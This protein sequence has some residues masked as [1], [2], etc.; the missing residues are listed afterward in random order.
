MKETCRQGQNTKQQIYALSLSL[1]LEFTYAVWPDNINK[2]IEKTNIKVI[3]K[4][5]TKRTYLNE[6]IKR[7]NK[8]K[9]FKII[10]MH[11]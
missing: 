8:N 10:D 11:I 6:M 3:D 1:F 2:E 4:T 9:N 5:I 7:K